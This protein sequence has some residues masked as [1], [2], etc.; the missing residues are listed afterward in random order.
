M[1]VSAD[2]HGVRFTGELHLERRRPIELLRS[3]GDR[4]RFRTAHGIGAVADVPE[5]FDRSIR[6]FGT[7]MQL[8]LGRLRIGVVGQGGT[9]SAVTELLIRLGVGEV[10]VFD[11]QALAESNVPRVYGSGRSAVG[12]PKVMIAKANA[13]RIGLGT[14]VTT[15][16]LRVTDR[17]ALN[18]LRGCDVVFGCTDDHAGRA[19]LSRFAFWYLVP[20]IDLGL[21]ISSRGGV[22]LGDRWWDHDDPPGAP[23]MLCRGAIDPARMRFEALGPQERARLVAEGYAPEL[24]DPDP[25]VVVHTTMVATFAVNELLERLIGFGGGDPPSELLIRVHD[26]EISRNRRVSRPGCYCADPERWALGEEDPPLGL[27]WPT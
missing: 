14:R 25:A 12:R 13:R 8:M 26:R 19:D 1:I 11:D 23:C 17:D 18:L 5:A 9:G 2:E 6:A 15:V 7:D 22:D 24:G 16:P 27:S 21:L 20:V 4:L 10:V 3:V